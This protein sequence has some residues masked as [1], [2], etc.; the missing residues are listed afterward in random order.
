[1]TK[2]YFRKY[3]V[4]RVT[5]DPREGVTHSLRTAGV[6]DGRS[7][8]KNRLLSQQV[9]FRDQLPRRPLRSCQN[10]T[11]KRNNAMIT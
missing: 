3:P 10:Q 11:E 8:Q 7:S 4:S 1:M 6:V 5:V 9:S 2:I